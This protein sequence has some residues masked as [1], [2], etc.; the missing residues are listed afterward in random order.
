VAR[1]VQGA[2]FLSDTIWSMG[3]VGMVATALAYYLP[4]RTAEASDRD[5]GPISPRRR[6]WLTVGALAA[7]VMVAGGFLTRRPYYNTMVYRLDLPVAVEAIQI[8]INGAPE[9]MAVAYDDRDDGQLQVDAHGFGWLE[10]DYRMGF[11]TRLENHT[12]NIT[13]HIEAR[14][15]FAELDHALTLTLPVRLKGRVTVRLNHRSVDNARS[16]DTLFGRS[17][18]H[19]TGSTVDHG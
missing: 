4:G 15:Y 19:A 16:M 17:L 8:R 7:I 12:M 13:L 6:R 11:G 14:S 9:S 18:K 1:V 5:T 2:H 3:I 10:F